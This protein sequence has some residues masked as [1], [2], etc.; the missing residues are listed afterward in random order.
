MTHWAAFFSDVEHEVLPVTSGYRVTLTYNLYY[1]A[2]SIPTQLF[3][4]TS[5]GLYQELS[6]AL[7]TPHFL[8]NGGTL[9]FFCQH[10][11]VETLTDDKLADFSAQLSFLKGEDMIIY[12]VAKSLGLSVDLKAICDLRASDGFMSA[13]KCKVTI[14]TFRHEISIGY[15]LDASWEFHYDSEKDMLRK[16]FGEEVKSAENIRWCY[17]SKLSGEPILSTVYY[18]NDPMA[19]VFYQSAALLVQVPEFSSERHRLATNMAS[20]SAA[21]EDPAAKKIKTEQPTE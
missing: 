13:N 1:S 8:R 10:K 12:Q 7:Q 21:E 19:E 5:I 11:Y 15:S 16:E 2:P 9:G 17:K 18:G 6:S 14:P 4:V 20:C 3:D